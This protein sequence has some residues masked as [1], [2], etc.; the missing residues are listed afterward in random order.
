MGGIA[1]GIGAALYEEFAYDAQGQ[2]LTQS[3]MGYVLPSAHEVP[4]VDIVHH[5]TPSPHG[6][7][8]ER[9]GRIRLSRCAGGDRQR[10][11]RR[12]KA[13]RDRGE[14]AADQ[15]DAAR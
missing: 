4:Q 11:Q 7:R 1:H 14:R 8:A 10:R 13:A 9:L 15:D 6:L 2:L 5:V 12:G 3:F